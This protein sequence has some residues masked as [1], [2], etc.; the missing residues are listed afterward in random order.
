MKDRTGRIV[1]YTGASATVAIIL[2]I[3]YA[4]KGIYPFGNNSI[5]YYDM[6]QS[7]IPLYYHTWDVLHGIKSVFWD[8]YSGLGGSMGDTMGSFVF[9]PFN[10]FFLFIGRDSVIGYMSFL[11]LIKMAIA[12]ATMSFYT[13]KKHSDMKCFF[14]VLTGINYASCGFIIQYYTNI[15]FLDIVCLFPIIVYALELMIESKRILPYIVAMTVGFISNIYL[16]F[17]VCIYIVVRSFLM[18]RKMV[19]ADQKTVSAFLAFTTGVSLSFSSFSW[20]PMM[21]LLLKSNRTNISA[22]QMG[23]LDSITTIICNE[24]GQKQ[25]MLYGCEYLFSILIFLVVIKRKSLKRFCNRI[26]MITLLLL[27]IFIEGINLTWHM[28][29]YVHFP[30]RFGYMLSFET[31]SLVTDVVSEEWESTTCLRK[32]IGTYIS[33]AI[34]PF[35]AVVLFSFVRGFGEYGIRNFE[36]YKG[37][38]AVIAIIVICVLCAFSSEKKPVICGVIGCIV[39]IQACLGVYSFIGPEYEYSEECDLQLLNEALQAGENMDKRGPFC[40]NKDADNNMITNY[41]FVTGTSALSNWTWGTNPAI[42]DNLYSLGH[43]LAYTRFLDNGGTYFSDILFGVK[44]V[45]TKNERD[46]VLYSLIN[47]WGNKYY[48]EYKE[49]MPLG[50]L[51]STTLDLQ[52]TDDLF[53]NQNLL[54]RAITESNNNLID[55]YRITDLKYDITEYDSVR[56]KLPINGNRKVYMYSSD[57]MHSFSIQ[58][59]GEYVSMPYLMHTDNIFYPTPFQNGIIDCG[60]YSGGNVEV[61]LE[62]NEYFKGEE[63]ALIEGIRIGTMDTE[64]LKD[65]VSR[66]QERQDLEV[67]YGKR[68]LYINGTVSNDG[69]I[70]IPIGYNEGWKAKQDGESVKLLAGLNHSMMMIPVNKGEVNLELKYLPKGFS[71]GLCFLAVG[72]ITM[73]IVVV[74]YRHGAIMNICDHIGGISWPIIYLLTIGIIIFMYIIP[75]IAWF[76]IIIRRAI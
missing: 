22:T 47:K 8:W 45:V 26:I 66:L 19:R 58:I 10:L 4:L 72:I 65:A 46:G 69:Y 33:I 12:A 34:I 63:K 40:R 68:K 76:F 32:R 53:E 70:F 55:E 5:A 21:E 42:R 44:T 15:N 62:M 13:T 49:R 9:S 2:L 54:F 11:L 17:M 61:K 73:I 18:M 16:M 43:S 7:M 64:L 48:Y 27:P 25:F 56:V 6:T 29:G 31:I 38:I 37:Y 3:V 20:I 57:M 14:V 67:S 28:G 75:I 39:I 60:M 35:I 71:V 74:A 41:P 36:M 1:K 23:Y 59:D 52:Y 51:T 24:N 50:I 30:M